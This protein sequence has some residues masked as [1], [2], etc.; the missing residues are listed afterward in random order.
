MRVTLKREFNLCEWKKVRKELM[1]YFNLLKRIELKEK[2]LNK[3]IN[4]EG[5]P[6]NESGS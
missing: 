2:E 5:V 6:S 3:L 4:Q 1:W